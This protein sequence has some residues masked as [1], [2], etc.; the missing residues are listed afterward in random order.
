MR[1]SLRRGPLRRAA[2]I[3]SARDVPDDESEST[4]HTSVDA[5]LFARGASAKREAPGD[6]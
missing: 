1:I 3:F 5:N 6:E 2:A 4:H